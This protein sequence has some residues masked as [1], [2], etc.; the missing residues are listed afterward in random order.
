MVEEMIDRS[1]IEKIKEAANIVEVV[2]D[3]VS[4]KRSGA[5]YKGLCPFHN[6]KTP[7]FIVSPARGTFHCFGCGRG[8]DSVAFVM[9]H[10][11]MTYPEALRWL[12]KKYHIEVHER[13]L[14]EEEKREESE[15]ESMFIVNEWA[16]GYFEDLLHN[17]QDGQALGLQ[18]FRGRGFRDDTIRTFRLGYDLQD[19]RALAAEALRKGYK[20][21]FLV[22]TGI[23]YRNDRGDLIDR[24]AGR[25]VFPWVGLNGKVIGFTARVLDSRTKGVAQK[26]VNSPTSDIYN[27]SEALYGIFQ[28]RRDIGREDRV[29]LVE[30][31]ADVISMYQSGIRNVVAGS[32]TALTYPQIRML[33]RFTSNITLIYDDDP[34][35]IHAALRGTDMLLSEGMNLRILVLPDGDDPDSYARKHTPQELREFVDGHQI[36]FIQ[37]KTDLLLKGE[38]DPMKRS[39]AINSIVQSIAVVQDPILRDTYIHNCVQQTGIAEATLI[40]QMNRYIRQAR[41]QRTGVGQAQEPPKAPVQQPLAQPAAANQDEG[42]ERMLARMIVR[43]GEKVIFENVEGDD[44]QSYNLTVA[45]YIDYDLS[46]D[47]LHFSNQKYAQILQEAV[48]HSGEEGFKAEQYF[49]SHPDIDISRLAASLSQDRYQLHEA[50]PIVPLSD[51]AKALENRK[52]RESLR[53]QTVHLVLDFRL[54]YVEKRLQELKAQISEAQSDGSR[55]LSLMREYTDMQK[56]RNALAKKLGSEIIS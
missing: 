52:K 56:V 17:N 48:A 31:Q 6:E 18:Y 50:Q 33:H 35:G 14:S 8:G 53:N 45:Q 41:E 43:N 39:E 5:N 40:N 29:Y 12:A 1:T 2:S 24:Y 9:E 28:A 47:N 26:Y 7:S 30:G 19:R 10:E 16:C 32:G 4:L 22:K 27:K 25:V 37:F 36:D 21:E 55:L 38:R 11:Q 51:D 34:A 44:G 42:I 23:C 13:E 3:F 46:S 49:I 54:R 20:D 15:R